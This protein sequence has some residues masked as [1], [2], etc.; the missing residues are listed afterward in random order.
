MPEKPSTRA[1]AIARQGEVMREF[2]ARAVLFQEAVARSGGL[3]GSDLQAVGLLLSEGPATPGELAARTGL[4]AGGAVT[5]MIDRLERAGFVTRAR[6][7]NDR[8]RVI[9][10]AVPEA[11][12]G[13]VGHVYGRVAERW[14]EYLDTLTDEQIDF[15]NEF[16]VRAARLNQEETEALHGAARP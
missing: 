10:S 5:A 7:E 15:A 3:N 4:T 13:R 14:N 8:R 1:A 6:D 16:L 11:V 2:M 12:M 9:V